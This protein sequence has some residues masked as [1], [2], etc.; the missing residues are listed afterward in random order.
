[1]ATISISKSFPPLVVGTEINIQ[2]TACLDLA[3][4]WFP[5][6]SAQPACRQV[7]D[8]HPLRVSIEEIS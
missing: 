3:E 8:K 6:Y 4:I 5:N 2:P 1:M 7:S